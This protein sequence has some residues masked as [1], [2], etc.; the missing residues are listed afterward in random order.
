MSKVITEEHQNEKCNN[1]ISKNEK[2]LTE[3]KCN[4]CFNTMSK[5]K[6]VGTKF[7]IGQFVYMKETLTTKGYVSPEDKTTIEKYKIVN[8]TIGEGD[9]GTVEIVEITLK[10]IIPRGCGNGRTIFIYNKELDTIFLTREDAEG[11]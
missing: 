10:H 8:I 3:E 4:K 5:I 6:L 7:K 1:C 11:N 2:I 9:N